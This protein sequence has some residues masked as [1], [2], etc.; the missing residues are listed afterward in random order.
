M[1]QP[2]WSQV[3]LIREAFHYQSRFSG[4]TMVFKVDFPLTEDAGFSYFMKDIALLSQIGIRVVIVPGAKEWIDA[5]LEEYSIETSYAGN[6]RITSAEAIPFVNMAAFN[7]ATK[8]I[9]GLS[10][11]RVNAV[12]GSF[13][14]ARGL[15]VVD[16]I[17]MA[18]TGK[19]DK[20][21]TDTLEPILERGMVPILP[22]IG[23]SSSGKPYN[24]PS[25]EIALEVSKAL[26]A[27]KLFI[28]SAGKD[29]ASPEYNIPETIHTDEDG[30]L[31]RLTPQEAE[32]ILQAN[33]FEENK[34]DASLTE[35]H[36][37][38]NAS[39]AGI[40]RV[41]IIDGKQ[42]GAILRELFSNLGVGTMV[43][44]DE[45]E[46]IRPLNIED[47][48]DVLRLMEPLMKQG[49]LLRRSPED[50]QEKKD[51]YV[52]FEIDGS[53]H[54][55]AAMHDWGENQAEIAAIATDP[56][57]SDIGMGRRLVRYLIDKARKQGLHRVFVLTTK[58]HDWFELI[59]FKESIIEHLPSRKRACY[60][61]SRKSKIFSLDLQ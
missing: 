23:W 22:C 39:K 26:D 16:G 61:T 5:V 20:I 32:H 36:L 9:T 58:T 41:H 14:K 13:V 47:I 18:H 12:I 2:N 46:S 38:L 33:H 51:D 6:L 52:V 34:N 35:L 53:V 15:G 28:V 59:G 3:D 42:D 19:M 30:R 57:Y 54:A 29:I 45:Y 56:T 8:F 37:A 1:E 21:L 10:A 44:A 43:Y 31:I 4:T 17:D 40:E 48:P 11:S 60:D 50:I 25:D 24:I 49:I 27:V 7:V 55:C